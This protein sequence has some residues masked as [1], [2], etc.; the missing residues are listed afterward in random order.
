MSWDMCGITLVY[1]SLR[2][3]TIDRP[4]LVVKSCGLARG[5]VRVKDWRTGEIGLLAL[6]LW[7]TAAEL[8]SLLYDTAQFYSII[9]SLPW[10]L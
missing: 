5:L 10:W 9:V 3:P 7:A 1:V 8:G 6:M 4:S 2:L